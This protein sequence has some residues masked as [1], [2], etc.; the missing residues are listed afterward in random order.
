MPL[1]VYAKRTAEGWLV[2]VNGTLYYGATI[3]AAVLAAT[4]AK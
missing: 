2:S 3:E 1:N 4:E